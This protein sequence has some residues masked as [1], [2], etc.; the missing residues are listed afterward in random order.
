[1]EMSYNNSRLLLCIFKG[2]ERRLETSYVNVVYF[3]KRKKCWLTE[4]M[5]F[6]VSPHDLLL[7]KI[8]NFEWIDIIESE[9]L[10]YA[11]GV[12]W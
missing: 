11:Y 9:E 6:N 1:M 12:I 2:E 7:A 8:L 4:D 10:I 5:T 3:T